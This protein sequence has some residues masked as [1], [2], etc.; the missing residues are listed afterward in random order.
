MNGLK[1]VRARLPFDGALGAFNVGEIPVS[2]EVIREATA[3]YDRHIVPHLG[4]QKAIVSDGGCRFYGLHP[5]G[6]PSDIRWWSADDEATF[7][8]FQQLFDQVQP[9][10]AA[11]GLFPAGGRLYCGFFVTRSQ[12]SQADL[13][14]DYMEECGASAYTLMT[15]LDDWKGTAGQLIY[16]DAIGRIR[17]YQYKKGSAI[18]LGASFQHGTQPCTDVPRAFLC[19]AFGSS[20]ARDWRHIRKTVLEQSRLVRRYDGTL[21]DQRQRTDFTY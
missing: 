1:S 12:C 19:F 21:V 9:A 4:S 14:V 13:H 18:V 15:P 17:C 6:W 8:K 5:S 20:D 16:R 3:L 7:S 11:R 2:R 10:L